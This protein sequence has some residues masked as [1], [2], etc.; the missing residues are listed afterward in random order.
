MPP[1]PD[2]VQVPP[3]AF[4]RRTRQLWK[5][6]IGAVVLPLPLVALGLRTLH[7][8]TSDQPLGEVLLALTILA[9]GNLTIIA[10]LASVRCP[11]CRVRLLKA[12]FQSPRG[13]DALT[14]L[15]AARSCPACGFYP[16]S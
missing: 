6:V 15:L 9:G 5:L 10:L 1:A 14:A 16:P 13:F 2:R 3:D 11:Q 7:R 12:P 8:I 4:L